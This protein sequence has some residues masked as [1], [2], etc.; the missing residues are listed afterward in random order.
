MIPAAPLLP[1]PGAVYII[2]VDVTGGVP[3][4]G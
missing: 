4:P 1:V 2:L 3:V